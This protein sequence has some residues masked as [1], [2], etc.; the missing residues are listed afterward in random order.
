MVKRY[1]TVDRYKNHKQKLVKKEK[2]EEQKE[3]DELEF[4][5]ARLRALQNERRRGQERKP[6]V[7][8]QN[9]GSS[10]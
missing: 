10:R 4:S 7:K 2:I 1:G 3:K 6:P 8:K 9:R 5:V